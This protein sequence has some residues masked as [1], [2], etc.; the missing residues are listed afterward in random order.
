MGI[1]RD[2]GFLNL[3]QLLMRVG[4]S[5]GKCTPGMDKISNVVDRMHTE[6]GDKSV[7]SLRIKTQIFERLRCVMLYMVPPTP[8]RWCG[9]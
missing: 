8:I 4:N 9:G 2:A 1:R 5:T 3:D 6:L 7:D